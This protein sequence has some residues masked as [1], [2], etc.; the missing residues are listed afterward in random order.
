MNTTSRQLS[1]SR[2]SLGGQPRGG[3]ECS[4]EYRPTFSLLRANLWRLREATVS[5][6]LGLLVIFIEIPALLWVFEWMKG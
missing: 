3:V 2:S 6:W 1:S 5:E 4:S